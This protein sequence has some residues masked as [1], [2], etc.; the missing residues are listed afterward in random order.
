ME[1]PFSR[2]EEMNSSEVAG[3]QRG[4]LYNQKPVIAAVY[5]GMLGMAAVV[6]TFGN[7]V[8]IT[9]VTFKYFR[10]LQHRRESND[11]GRAFIANLAFSDLIVTAVINPLAIAGTSALYRHNIHNI[12]YTRSAVIRQLK[13]MIINTPYDLV[14]RGLES[15]WIDIALIFLI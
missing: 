14:I 12:S 2:L 1:F 4:S 6:G 7:L 11:V 8:A 13:G 10:S 15:H 9:I 5:V 3:D